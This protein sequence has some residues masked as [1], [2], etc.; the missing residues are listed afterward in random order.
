M[1]ERVCF[2]WLIRLFRCLFLRSSLVRLPCRLTHRYLPVS[3]HACGFR[4]VRCGPK[5]VRPQLRLLVIVGVAS[6]SF[7]GLR[8]AQYQ[9][10]SKGNLLIRKILADHRSLESQFLKVLP[11]IRRLRLDHRIDSTFQIVAYVPWG[12]RNPAHRDNYPLDVPSDSCGCR[13]HLGQ[14]GIES[15]DKDA[16]NPSLR[17]LSGVAILDQ[18]VALAGCKDPVFYEAINYFHA[19]AVH[20]RCNGGVFARALDHVGNE[21][22]R[23]VG[24][25]VGCGSGLLC[26]GKR[27]GALKV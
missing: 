19:L 23:F 16:F 26:L 13:L 8:R 11:E 17:F 3:Q 12:V 14:V 9:N 24:Y 27:G 25:L 20:G 2:C 21:L 18:P 15:S 4:L 7:G 22:R 10:L 6:E 5:Q 1:I